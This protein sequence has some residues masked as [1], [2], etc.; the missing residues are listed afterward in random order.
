[1]DAE[2]AGAGRIG[3][4]DVRRVDETIRRLRAVDHRFGG[5]SCREAVLAELTNARRMFAATAPD[6]VRTRLCKAVADLHN[7]AGWTC[8]DTGQ[9]KAALAHFTQALELA[10]SVGARDLTANIHYRIG[11]VRLH[12]NDSAH[13]LTDFQRGERVARDSHATLA[14]S[15]LLANQAWAHATLGQA[16]DALRL[17]GQAADAFEQAAPAVVPSWLAFY[18][19]IDLS[20]L[21]GVIYTELAQRVDTSYTSFAIPPLTAAV[22]GYGEARTRSRALSLTALA[23]NHFID[24]DADQGAKTGTLALD[25]AARLKSPRTLERMR[26]LRNEAHRHHHNRDVRDLIDRMDS[27]TSQ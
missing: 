2:G 27:L 3:L 24:G 19:Q 26:P 7:L 14:T 13:A 15:L 5:G 8:F 18:D 25:I 11:R 4:S 17:L 12:H 16:D 1:M 22:A 6:A 20:G 21:T 9:T 23:I 10:T